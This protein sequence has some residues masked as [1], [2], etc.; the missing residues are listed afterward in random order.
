MEAHLHQ[1]IVKSI[2]ANEGIINL[3]AE[4]SILFKAIKIPFLS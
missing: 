1:K 3:G 4:L 2:L